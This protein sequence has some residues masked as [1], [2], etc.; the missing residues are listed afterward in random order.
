[1][2]KLTAYLLGLQYRESIL[3]SSNESE[4][5]ADSDDESDNSS[6]W[7]HASKGKEAEDERENMSA[8]KS[9]IERVK[10]SAEISNLSAPEGTLSQSTPSKGQSASCDDGSSDDGNLSSL[11]LQSVVSNPR[12]FPTYL[13]SSLRTSQVALTQAEDISQKVLSEVTKKNARQQQKY[14]S[15]RG[16]QRVGGRQKGSKGKMDDRLKMDRSH[17]WG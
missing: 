15:K 14:H 8:D 10:P 17:V 4:D 1:M 7:S 2:T 3:H 5:L 6:Q 16:P 13:L 11:E 12:A 9:D